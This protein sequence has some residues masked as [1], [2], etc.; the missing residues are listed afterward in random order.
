[1]TQQTQDREGFRWQPNVGVLIFVAV[2]LPLTIALGF[3]QLSREAEKQALLDEYRAREVAV[4]VAL[5]SLDATGDHQYRRV[6]V[7]GSFNNEFTVLLENRVRQGKPGFEVVT[8]FKVEDNG[9]LL[10]V[11]RGWI[12]GYL[13]RDRLP[14]VPVM[15]GSAEI[16]GHLY[17]P[18]KEPFV[19]GDEVWRSQWPQ[20][21]QNLDTAA[22]AERLKL[23]PFP[24]QLRLD[25]GSRG[26]LLPG[27][28]VVNVTPEKHRGYAVQWFAMAFALAVLAIFANSNLAIWLFG[29]K[30]Q[31]S[32]E[33]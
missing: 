27:W 32:Q 7:R 15:T 2:F 13:E 12:A 24:Y 10:W 23:A 25:Q 8:L 18:L 28:E 16:F 9:A 22:L 19:V 17:R 31:E 11:N 26:A 21:L 20:V 6:R 1:M 30:A 4:P 29:K 14:E 3:W 33:R 5:G